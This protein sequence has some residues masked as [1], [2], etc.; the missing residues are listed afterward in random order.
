M[1]QM[2]NEI[3]EQKRSSTCTVLANTTSRQSNLLLGQFKARYSNSTIEVLEFLFFLR[4]ARDWNDLLLQLVLV[5]SLTLFKDSLRIFEI[6]QVYIL[7]C[8][9]FY[10]YS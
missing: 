6:K 5:K 1:L 7:F 8:A 2:E 4:T 10:V 9:G 3:N